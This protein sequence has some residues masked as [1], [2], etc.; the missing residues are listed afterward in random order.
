MEKSQTYIGSVE[1]IICMSGTITKIKVLGKTGT[2]YLS[3][4]LGHPKPFFCVYVVSLRCNLRCKH[5]LV[6]SPYQEDMERKK[7]WDG[8]GSDLT[9]EQAKYALDQLNRI[10]IS[11]LHLTGGEPLLRNDLEEIALH[12]KKKGMYVSLDTNGTL[13]T[14]ERA[15]S[16][17]CFDRI[18]VSVDGMKEAHEKIRGENTFKKAIHAV[19]LLKNYSDSVVGMVFTINNINYQDIEQVL[20][21]ARGHCDFITFL[22]VDHIKELSLDKESA[23]EVGKMIIRLKKENE[24]FIENPIEYIELIP[25]FLQGKT[26]IDY[27]INCHPF[28]LYYTLGPSG[29]LSGCISLRSR[30][31]NI[32]KDDIIDMHRQG[33]SMIEDVRSKCEGCT[34]TCTIQNSLLFQQP[35]H[36]AASTA[37][38]KLLRM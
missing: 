21:F 1:L 27:N 12:A 25:H 5:C 17:S 29:D 15:K 28:A 13:M 4:K 19:E 36:K 8:L 26:S 11:M 24:S 35:V 20:E 3:Y 18:G 23:K 9:T 34:L 10:G 37:A 14:R 22:P 33:M 6:E 16:L 31:G 32:L 7:Y 38:S 2:R 30:V